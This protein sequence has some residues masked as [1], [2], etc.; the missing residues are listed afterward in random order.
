[1]HRTQSFYDPIFANTKDCSLWEIQEREEI[2]C[3]LGLVSLF[4][5]SL[6][7]SVIYESRGDILRS[8]MN[9]RL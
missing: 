9:P 1:M 7:F 4:V 6:S 8:E 5:L 3:H 2:A